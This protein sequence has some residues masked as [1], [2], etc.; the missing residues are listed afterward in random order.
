M[1]DARERKIEHLMEAL[2]ENTKSKALFAAADYTIQMRGGT[3][4]VPTGQIAELLQ[5]AEKNGSV[6]AEEIAGVLDTN[7]ISVDYEASWSVDSE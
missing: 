6:T 4:A 7:T 2:D 5:L 3:T 1:T